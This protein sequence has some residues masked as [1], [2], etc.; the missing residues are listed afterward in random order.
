MGRYRHFIRKSDLQRWLIQS[1][2]N[3]LSTGSEVVPRTQIHPHHRENCIPK[4]IVNQ[5]ICLYFQGDLTFTQN[6]WMMNNIIMLVAKV[7]T[8]YANKKNVQ[9]HENNLP[10]E[11]ILLKFNVCSIPSFEYRSFVHNT[12]VPYNHLF[13]PFNVKASLTLHSILIIG[14]TAF[15]CCSYTFNNGK[16][17]SI[18]YH[19][20]L[21]KI[22][23]S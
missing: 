23:L 5:F 14:L 13:F 19:I 17:N 22:V 1:L 16:S 6:K 7:T 9:L 18:S 8:C 20:F 3:A 10:P 2:S 15:S 21:F 4:W 11:I 12:A